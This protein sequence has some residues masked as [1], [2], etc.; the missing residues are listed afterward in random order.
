MVE[1]DRWACDT[2]KDNKP[3]PVTQ[4][5]VRGMSY[6]GLGTIDLVSGGPPCQPFSLGGKHNAHLDHR[7]MFPEAIRAVREL[8]AQGLRVREREGPDAR[9]L[10]ELPE[11]YPAAACSSGGHGPPR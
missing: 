3:W 9:D 10:P 1:W 2:L 6:H 4:G 7:D 5:D 8:Q 11:L